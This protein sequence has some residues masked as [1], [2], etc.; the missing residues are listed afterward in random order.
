MLD[1][2]AYG[3]EQS[4][5]VA[6]HEYSAAGVGVCAD[7]VRMTAPIAAEFA[8]SSMAVISSQMR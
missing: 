7:Y 8:A 5:F 6:D 1:V 3:V 4:V 2:V